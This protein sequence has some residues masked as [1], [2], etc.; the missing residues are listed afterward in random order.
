[1]EGRG[2]SKM[3]AQHDTNGPNLP[4]TALIDHS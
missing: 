4:S 1:M 2:R 3:I